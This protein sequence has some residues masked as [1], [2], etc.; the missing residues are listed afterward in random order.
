MPGY[1]IGSP[2]MT[3]PIGAVGR[4]SIM[5]L[6]FSQYFGIDPAVIEEYGAF[7]ICL[8]SDLPLF[9]DPFL[10]FNSDKRKYQELHQS[11]LHYLFFLRDRASQG[12]DDG[13][14]ANW[15]R[16]K[17]VKQNWLGYTVLGNDGTGLGPDFATALHTALRTALSD[18]GQE[19]ISN[20]SHLEKLCLIKG[21]VGR[22]NI[23]DFTTNLINDFLLKYTERFARK[24]LESDNCAAFSVAHAVFNYD[25]ETWATRSY[26]L[27][28]CGGDF[29]IL[30][31]MDILTRDNTWI[32][33]KDMV[34]KFDQ[35]PTAVSNAELRAQINQY[36]RRQLGR[37]PTAK[38][39]REAAQETINRY[40]E[41][42]DHYIKW[43]ESEG[44]RAEAAS[45]KKVAE[46]QAIFVQQIQMAITA[47]ARTNEFYGTPATSYNECL[48]RA[49]WFKKYVEDRDGYKVINRG[50]EPF[51]RESE[52]QVF[53]GLV[54]YGTDFDVNREP[55][56]GRGP[57]DFKVSKGAIDKSLIEFKLGSNA[58]LERNLEK[59]VAV[60]EAANETQS[61][62]KVIICYTEKDQERV[63]RILRK[64]KLE[65]ESIIVID[66]RS[67]NKISASRA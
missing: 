45:T 4:P 31:P 12:L 17:E 57:V 28:Q 6:Y 24:H 26:Y 44:D 54:W 15:Y 1:W 43:Q 22:D 65:K 60:Y 32:S 25:T 35:L 18:F 11:I 3:R 51:S 67:D 59:Q 5:N 21:G 66:A 48:T 13:L 9:I 39:R 52:V 16:F 64:L 63:R 58:Q 33:H 55:N 34:G 30:T 41:L 7:D 38:E 19:T 56:N 20:G 62:V 8:A 46:T 36:F 37:N 40:P 29:V 47:L 14:V 53:F 61:S 10:L 49:K 2:T 50:G 42:I 27:P 23:S